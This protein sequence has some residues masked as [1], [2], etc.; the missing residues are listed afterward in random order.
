MRAIHNHPYV[1]NKQISQSPFA[2]PPPPTT[3]QGKMR[4]GLDEHNRPYH[5]E[6]KNFTKHLLITGTTGF[7]KTSFFQNTMTFLHKMGTKFLAIDIKKDTRELLHRIP[8]LILRFKENTN[9][10]LNPLQRLPGVSQIEQDDL[11]I[12]LLAETTFLAE[13]STS[14]LLDSL[15]ELRNKKGAITVFDLYQSIEEKGKKFRT[16]RQ[17]GWRD[18]CLRSLKTLVLSFGPMLDC[19]EGLPI[20]RIIQEHNVVAELDSAG[21]YKS[22]FGTLL[23]AYYLKWKISNNIKSPFHANFCDE[24]NML[25]SKTIEFH[26]VT[27]KLSIL[28]LIELGREFQE[29]W[30][31]SSQEPKKLSESVKCNTATKILLPLED[32]P[33]RN[34]M[35]DTVGMTQTQTIHTTLFVTGQSVV[36]QEGQ[37][38][39]KI[40]LDP[41]PENA[42][43]TEFSDQEAE[44]ESQPIINQYPTKMKKQ[45]ITIEEFKPAQKCPRCGTGELIIKEGK[46]GKFIACNQ[47][48]NC[49]HTEQL[50]NEQPQELTQ[51]Q[52]ELLWH[53]KLHPE[54]SKT[55]HYKSLNLSAGKADN[56]MKK[57]RHLVR[58]IT[59]PTQQRGR[60]PILL[61]LTKQACQQLGV[62]QPRTRG[63]EIEHDF[64]V[65][66]YVAQLKKAGHKAEPNFKLKDKEADIGIM[67]PNGEIIAV[68][69][70]T[71]TT[72]EWEMQQ[73]IKNIKAGFDKT[74][75]INTNPDKSQEFNIKA[76]F[77]L[78]PEQESKITISQLIPDITELIRKEQET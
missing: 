55:Q 9:F 77:Q 42:G 24:G 21:S 50:K 26:S 29:S 60:Q 6:I 14:L 18:S 69:I 70:S 43:L 39:H 51:Q 20:H 75:I 71:T 1:M 47:Y 17:L 15:C 33:S 56:L 5:L 36:K 54:L 34:Y 73:A 57:M 23:P 10:K 61:A 22:F 28:T 62:E 19:A 45:T 46:F 49:K 31:I 48:P 65:A 74:I 59:I 44:Q 53:I 8:M 40:T 78:S 68:E 35:S 7:G 58:E 52:K 12:R 13:G 4:I 3:Q 67:L 11:F 41:P 38:P 76:Q 72:P 64:H 32:G 16:L 66:R 37:K 63:A 25:L 27:K 2:T 30:F